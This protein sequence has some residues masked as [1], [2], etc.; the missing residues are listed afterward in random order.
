MSYFQ[1]SPQGPLRIQAPVAGPVGQLHALAIGQE[2]N[3]V[4]TNHVAAPDGA[5]ADLACRARPMPLV[6]VVN[7]C[8]LQILAAP[9]GRCLT[10]PQG[11]ARRRVQLSAM[12]GSDNLN[13]KR[14]PQRPRSLFSPAAAH[15]H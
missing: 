9:P 6:A 11:R 8:L 3:G 5:E 2:V 12:A 4:V 14:R 1:G 7:S 13:L 10:Q 15:V